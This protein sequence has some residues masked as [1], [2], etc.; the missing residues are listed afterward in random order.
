MAESATVVRPGHPTSLLSNIR[1]YAFANPIT[2]LNCRRLFRQRITRYFILSHFVILGL[3]VY[4]GA[5]K[6]ITWSQVYRINYL[7]H[8]YIS[9]HSSVATLFD[10]VVSAALI[11]FFLIMPG[12]AAHAVSHERKMRVD[13]ALRL[14]Q[15]TPGQI[16]IGHYL[17]SLWTIFLI[18][19]S[20]APFLLYGHMS[21]LYSVAQASLVLFV[22]IVYALVFAAIGQFAGSCFPT[23]TTAGTVAYAISAVVGS[24]FLLHPQ[25]FI[26]NLIQFNRIMILIPAIDLSLIVILLIA[27]REQQADFYEQ[28]RLLRVALFSLFIFIPLLCIYLDG[29]SIRSSVVDFSFLIFL[30]LQGIA[31]L[32]FCARAPHQEQLRMPFGAALRSAAREFCRENPLSMP[33]FLLITYVSFY[34]IGMMMLYIATSNHYNR[35]WSYLWPLV[36][37]GLTLPVVAAAYMGL[38]MYTAFRLSSTRF[39]NV[40]VLITVSVAISQYFA[41]CLVH[42]TWHLKLSWLFAPYLFRD[43]IYSHWSSSSQDPRYANCLYAIILHAPFAMIFGYAYRRLWNRRHAAYSGLATTGETND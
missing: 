33:I 17:T 43:A 35:E 25:L 15:L 14:T 34:A 20:L 40:A 4:Y 3:F 16:V 11:T 32:L 12:L 42:V 30:T 31:V 10:N 39:F 7:F 18:S 8:V 26:Q 41:F 24:P 1:E 13:D 5:D 21:G 6:Y 38:G 27:A 9:P 28:G 23:I 36:A 19:I 37:T 29:G 2:V 22:L